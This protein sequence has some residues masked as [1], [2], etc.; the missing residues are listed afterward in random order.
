MWYR[1][2]WEEEQA[3]AGADPYVWG[4]RRTRKEVDKILEDCH[5]QGLTVRKFEPEKM[6]H[7]STLET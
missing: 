6:F 2:L 4:L 1:A 5:R 3:A 7:P